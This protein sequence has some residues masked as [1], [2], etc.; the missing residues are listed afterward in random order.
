MK[1]LIFLALLSSF[2]WAQAILS[3]QEY[4]K[5]SKNIMGSSPPINMMIQSVKNYKFPSKISKKD[6]AFKKLAS[7]ETLV[8]RNVDLVVLWSSAGNYSNLA[9]KLHKVGI[10]TCSLDLST[11]ENYVEGY[12][13]LGSIM[14]EQKRGET[15][16]LYSKYI[17]TRP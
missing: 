7:I 8:K 3:C 16:S 6:D 9:N 10:D 15:L 13:V 2:T 12:K 17:A 1:N 14:N 11:L 5:K 4:A